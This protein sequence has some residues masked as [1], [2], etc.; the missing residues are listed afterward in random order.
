[1]FKEVKS[2]KW[3]DENHTSILA[4][5]ILEGG[6]EEL[7]VVP[8]AINKGYEP[9]DQFVSGEFG[10]IAEFVPVVLAD[11]QKAEGIRAER[12]YKLTLVD[13]LVMNPLRWSGFT[14]AERQELAAYRQALLDITDQD[15]FPKSVEWPNNPTVIKDQNNGEV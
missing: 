11:E 4:M 1:M 2:M 6:H 15:T 9:F 10:E 8:Y 12:D 7:G 14:E 5:V 13:E 3:L